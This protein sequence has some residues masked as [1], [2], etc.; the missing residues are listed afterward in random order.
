MDY[1]EAVQEGKRRVNR[2]ISILQ[3]VAGPCH[4]ML[5]LKLGV[6][7]WTPV[8]EETLQKIIPGKEDTA[9]LVV[10]DSDG[11]AKAM[12]AWLPAERAKEHSKLL[13]IRGVNV[14]PGEVKLPI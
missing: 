10:C 2:A 14:F 8:G 3:D 4:A 13:E 1:F 5:F 11:N 12:S 7:D 9:S 6:S